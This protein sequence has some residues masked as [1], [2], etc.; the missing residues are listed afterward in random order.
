MRFPRRVTSKPQSPNKRFPKL[1][2]A[3]AL[4]KESHLTHLFPMLIDT[5][6]LRPSGATSRPHQ[7]GVVSHTQRNRPSWRPG[8]GAEQVGPTPF[9]PGSKRSLPRQQRARI[10][11]SWPTA[12]CL[13]ARQTGLVSVPPLSES[14]TLGAGV[15]Q[16]HL[17]S[18]SWLYFRPS[19][20]R[21]GGR[22]WKSHPA[23]RTQSLLDWYCPPPQ[24]HTHLGNSPLSDAT[25]K[26]TPPELTQDTPWLS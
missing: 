10:L 18:F 22:W 20:T 4:S 1:D 24:A 23:G 2:R 6:K 7:G 21:L 12:M 19:V 17:T 11:Q 3:T 8:F 9:K 26:A 15:N 25:A 5:Q 14:N 16:H 13:T